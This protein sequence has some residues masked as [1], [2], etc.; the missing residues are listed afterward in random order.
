LEGGIPYQDSIF[1]G[2]FAV[3]GALNVALYSTS[4]EQSWQKFS[5]IEGHRFAVFAW[6]SQNS[7][8]ARGNKKRGCNRRSATLEKL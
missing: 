2:V 5:G 1:H 8:P 6:P 7:G 3:S 4:V